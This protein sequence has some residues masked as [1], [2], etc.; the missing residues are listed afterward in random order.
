MKGLSILGSTG[1]IGTNA[2]RVV[3]AFPDRLRVVALAAGRNVSLLAEQVAKYHPQAVAVST[4]H[5][6]D[7]LA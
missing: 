1:S 6:R 5:G 4:A 7:T 3:D 2:L